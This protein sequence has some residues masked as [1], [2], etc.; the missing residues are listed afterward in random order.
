MTSAS[1]RAIAALRGESKLRGEV[2]VPEWSEYG[3]VP[4]LLEAG[5]QRAL[6]KTNTCQEGDVPQNIITREIVLGDIALGL[7]ERDLVTDHQTALDVLDVII[8]GEVK[9][10]RIDILNYL[11][12]RLD[13]EPLELVRPFVVYY[14]QLTLAE[15]QKINRLAEGDDHKSMAYM[16]VYGLE[17]EHGAKVFTKEHIPDLMQAPA[18]LIARLSTEISRRPGLTDSVKKS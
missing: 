10:P 5:I 3:D 13:I 18:A 16:L 15:T 8:S 17:D 4:A 7:V 9:T 6:K 2:S 12:E 11:A 1:E 14:R